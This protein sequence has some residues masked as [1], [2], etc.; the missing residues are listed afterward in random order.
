MTTQTTT[1]KNGI[2]SLPQSIRGAWE[3]ADV[4]IFPTEN[5]LLIKKVEKSSMK[6]SE[7]ADRISP[8]S[9]SQEEISKE[10]KL[11]RKNK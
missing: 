7:I 5:A 1:I 9:M 6:L 10:I 4:L 8:K 11:F 2:V 3:Q